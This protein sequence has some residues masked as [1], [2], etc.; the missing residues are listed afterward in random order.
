MVNAEAR[1]EESR[2]R[3]RLLRVVSQEGPVSVTTLVERVGLTETAV[4]RHV[5]RLHAAG[6]VASRD[7][8]GPRR[9]GRPAKAWVLTDAGHRALASDYDDLA[10]EALG[11]LRRTGGERAVQAFAEE[12]VARLEA[13]IARALDAAPQDASAR[14]GALVEALNAEGYSASARPVGT[15]EGPAALTGVQLCQGHCPVQHVAAQFPELCEAETEAFS[16]VLGV[17][18][19]R[20]ATLAHGDHVCT[21]FVPTPTERPSR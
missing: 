16:R 13:R 10:G 15:P 6:L 17:H 11:F 12:R 21:T 8:A 4:R 20:L 1:A 19:Q 14:A 9:R 7:A 18:V 3:D 5:E 2:T